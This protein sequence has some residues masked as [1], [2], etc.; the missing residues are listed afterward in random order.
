ME[1]IGL[2]RETDVM[3]EAVAESSL[4]ESAITREVNIVWR[5][6]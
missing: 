3:R 4:G 6:G 5:R 1:Y 2:E